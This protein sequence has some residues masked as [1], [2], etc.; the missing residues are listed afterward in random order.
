MKVKIGD[1]E[2]LK[3]RSYCV[4]GYKN[5]CRGCGKE[6]FVGMCLENDLD[7]LCRLCSVEWYESYQPIMDT[8]KQNLEDEFSRK[9][10]KE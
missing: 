2:E 1:K 7:D 8:F 4:D 9:F 6:Y 10:T 3:K 5:T